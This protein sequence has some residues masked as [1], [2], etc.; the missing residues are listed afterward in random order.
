MTP[1]AAGRLVF[2]G[3]LRQRAQR[4]Y[5]REAARWG[6]S[7][8]VVCFIGA[9]LVVTLMNTRHPRPASTPADPP[10]A[11]AVD[12]APLPA[13]TTAP[14]SN[15]PP[16]PQQ[17]QTAALPEPEIPPKI[18]APPSPAPKPLI[19][20]ARQ[21]KPTRTHPHAPARTT[22]DTLSAAEKTSA[23]QASDAPPSSRTM[24][25]AQS[26]PSA[27]GSRTPATWQAALLARLEQFKR[28][29]EAARN[30]R[31]EGTAMLTFTM[32]RAGHV[33]SARLTGSSR[34]A[35]LD[36]ETLALIHRAEPLPPP[37]D[38]IH[39]ARLTLTVPVEFFLDR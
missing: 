15:L 31:D 36:E 11:I 27:S 16:D 7:A 30:N 3:L 34:H 38:T 37:P 28:Y 12:L 5:Q 19:A 25:P 10:A 1:D 18:I 9:A 33:L 20:A 13:S 14:A 21:K 24:I 32:D 6:L 39:G 4:E 17:Q 8:G 29:P 22:S 26:A 35:L 23:P 2:A